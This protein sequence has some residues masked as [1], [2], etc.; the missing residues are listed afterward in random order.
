MT[1]TVKMALNPNATNQPTNQPTLALS[2]T[3]PRL[4]VRYKSFENTLEK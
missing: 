2:K 1:L 3:S 4:Y